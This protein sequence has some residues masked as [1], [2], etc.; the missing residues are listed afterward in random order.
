[1]RFAAPVSEA[2]YVTQLAH[3]ADNVWS[4]ACI[5][6]GQLLVELPPT[7]SAGPA[8]W[9]DPYQQVLMQTTALL[10]YAVAR[11]Q[12]ADPATV[13]AEDLRTWLGVAQQTSL[14]AGLATMLQ[15]AGHDL[16]HQE[17]SDDRV[18]AVWREATHEDDHLP[19]I[20][21]TFGL[22]VGWGLQH[23]AGR[24]FASPESTA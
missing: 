7:A 21:G 3:G 1:M 9:L 16:D 15:A 18:V 6:M 5:R 20:D 4:N 24:L 13:T 14:R 11:Q 19:T 10:I 22:T 2:A 23:L 8:G 12:H 17:Q